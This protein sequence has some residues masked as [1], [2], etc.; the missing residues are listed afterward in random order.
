[1]P[2]MLNYLPYGTHVMK[3]SIAT[4]YIKLKN[5]LGKGDRANLTERL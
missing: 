5:T 2:Y 1:M 3:K 4:T